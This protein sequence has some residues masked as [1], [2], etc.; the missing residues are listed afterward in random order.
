MRYSLDFLLAALLLLEMAFFYLPP[1]LHEVVGTA[2][3]LPVF[4]HLALN[5]RYLSTLGTGRWNGLRLFRFLSA[6][7]LAA[8]CLVTVVSGCLISSKLFA[9]FV[10]L[11]VRGNPQLYQL[12]SMAARYF[13]VLAGLH[14]GVHGAAL[15]QR[16]QRLAGGA[17]R[18]AA[19]RVSAALVAVAFAVTGLFAVRA[20]DLPA[21]LAGKHVFLTD[22]LAFGG[23]KYVLAQLCVLLLFAEAGW[24]LTR[25]LS[26]RRA[27][28]DRGEAERRG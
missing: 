5:R 9:S 6:F 21:R 20:D 13:L 23:A 17:A 25:L 3:L 24:L 1:L 8:A 7:L 4:C 15:W 28:A 26:G 12:H 11:S 2:F 10:P 19:A 22:A 14:L 18:P 16:L 27:G